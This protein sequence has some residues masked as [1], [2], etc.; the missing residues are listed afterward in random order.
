MTSR[1][2]EAEGRGYFPF[3]RP[4]VNCNWNEVHSSHALSTKLCSDCVAYP[5]A[6]IVALHQ[7]SA[8]WNSLAFSDLEL[9]LSHFVLFR[10]LILPENHVAPPD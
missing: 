8:C 9:F 5:F 7:R 6:V 10:F 2:A 1:Q 4:R 3:A